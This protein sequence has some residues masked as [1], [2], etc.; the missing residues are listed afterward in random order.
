MDGRRLPLECDKGT[1]DYEKGDMTELSCWYQSLSRLR[2]DIVGDFAAKELFAI[3]GDSLLLYCVTKA[4]VDFT[5][6]CDMFFP[7]IMLSL[8]TAQLT[9]L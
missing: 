9:F 2:V 6:T 4:E 1:G 5:G 3:H 8:Q 7:V